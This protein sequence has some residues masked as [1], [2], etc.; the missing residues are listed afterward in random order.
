MYF[1]ASCNV[2]ILEAQLME[3]DAVIPW[4]VLYMIFQLYIYECIVRKFK[5]W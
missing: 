2:T 3:K 1:I 4:Y 5:I